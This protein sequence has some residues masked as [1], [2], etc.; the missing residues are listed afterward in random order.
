MATYISLYRLTQQ[1]IQNIKDS[2]TRLDKAKEA[3]RATGGKFVAF[4]L[5]M[6]Q[7]DLVTVAEWPD[8]AS[9]AKFGLM[10]GSGGNVRTETLKAFTEDEYRKLVS[11][12]P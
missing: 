8:D 6:G 11:E 9:A 2:P 5:T 12:L 1:G 3:I 4:Y 10:L 7:Y